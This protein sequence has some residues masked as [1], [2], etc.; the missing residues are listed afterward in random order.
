MGLVGG[1]GPCGRPLCLVEAPTGLVGCH[2]VKE[3]VYIG[4][5]GTHVGLIGDNR[6]F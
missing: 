6:V 3:G 2:L 4:Q 5:V 1:R